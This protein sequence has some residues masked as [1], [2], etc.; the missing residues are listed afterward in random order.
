MGMKH[1]LTKTEG[2]QQSSVVQYEYRGITITGT[3]NAS[4][5]SPYNRTREWVI[6]NGLRASSLADAKS[7]IDRIKDKAQLTK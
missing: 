6:G 3:S 5:S 1:N 4:S 2:H 7:R